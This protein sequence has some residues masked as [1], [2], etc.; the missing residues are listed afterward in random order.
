LRTS[1]AGSV[2]ER[3]VAQF[4]QKRARSEF[5]SPHEGQRRTVES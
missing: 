2:S 1:E 4:W 5:S 3:E